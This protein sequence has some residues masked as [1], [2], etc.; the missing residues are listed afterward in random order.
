MSNNIT[1]LLE[2]DCSGPRCTNCGQRDPFGIRAPMGDEA[3]MCH[4]CRTGE[5][6]LRPKRQVPPRPEPLV[7]PPYPAG[8]V[9]V[10]GEGL[11]GSMEEAARFVG[12]AKPQF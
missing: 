11:F 4:S 1:E 10:P 3:H 5:T 9:W 12:R 7:D 8:S 6:P 2:Y